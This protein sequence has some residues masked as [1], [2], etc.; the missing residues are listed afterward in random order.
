[1]AIALLTNHLVPYRVPLYERL[2]R[3]HDVEVVLYG[4]GERY[5][6]AWFAG[7]LE[8]QASSAPFPARLLTGG[9]PGVFALAGRYETVIAPYAGGAILPAAYLGARRRGRGFVLWASVWAQPHS[10]KNTLA[11]P[12]TRRIYRN[13]DAV[14]AYGEHVRGF[15]AGIR[16][17]DD[18]V[19]VAP[20][21]VEADLFGRPVRP[22]EVAAFRARHALPDGPLVLYAGR[23]VPEKGVAVLLAAW[24][25]AE[26]ADATLVLIGDGPLREHCSRS[27]F[28]RLLGPLAREELPVAYAASQFAVLPSIP[29][30]RFRE[31]WGLVC[32]EAMHQARPV[33]ATSA[34]GAAA[35]GL[36]RDG[37]TGLVVAP[38]DAGALAGALTRLLGDET[39]RCRLGQ[40]AQATVAAYNY[41][42][43][44]EAFDRA[45]A[46]TRCGSG[47]DRAPQRPSR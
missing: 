18:D 20:Q 46:L 40:L 7:D 8:T 38:G 11:R 42:A 45:L 41:D 32:N 25:R 35:G 6:P 4:G 12:L 24:R 5:V 37:E 44:L 26:V 9:A 1:M 3:E 19:F 34:V 10:F 36:V 28:A 13:A 31:P 23:L 39:L 27:P 43:M 16:G 14:I 30:R 47:R 21:S 2:A 15:V 17:R 22:E 29:T 33:I